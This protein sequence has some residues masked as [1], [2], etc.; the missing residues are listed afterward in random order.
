M[1]RAGQK[2][3]Q[4]GKGPGRPT[5]C[6]GAALERLW[7]HRGPPRLSSTETA[8]VPGARRPGKVGTGAQRAGERGSASPGASAAHA[9]GA[10]G[11]GE[12]AA[13]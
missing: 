11:R 5:L 8:R 4:A 10:G 6:P 1:L 7:E 13:A 9:V 2:L 3:T 12:E